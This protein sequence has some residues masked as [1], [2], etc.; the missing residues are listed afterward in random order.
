M[1]A[2]IKENGM[3]YEL[4]PPGQHRRNQAERAIQT[5]KSHFISILAGVDDKFPLSLWC[6]LLEPTELTLNLLRQSRITPNISAFAHVHFN[7]DYMRK[8]FALIGCAIQT[9]VKPDN[10]LSWDTRSEPGFNLGTLMEHHCCF[11]VYVTRTRATRISNTVFFKH[12]YITNPTI[13]PESHV[14]AAAQQLATALKGNI[15]AGN[16]TAEA[17]T[18][19]SDLF[20][21]IAAAKQ[22]TTAAK[23]QQ[24]RLRA[25]PTARITTH[26]PRLVVPLPRVAVPIPRVTEPSQAD[27]RVVQI[28][29]NPTVPRPVEQ[30]PATCSQSRS[31][32]VD[33]QSS[34]ARPNYISQDEEDDDDPPPPATD[35]TLNHPKHHARSNVRVH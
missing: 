2:C 16:E 11:R 12:Q 29:T 7:H 33:V 13:S 26:L 32:Q 24:N 35:N 34:A 17:L 3:T 21:K 10:H 4:V 14:V 18:K 25:N 20:T 31:P 19:V 8:P 5:F 9:H 1:I 23:E 27:C 30:A 28:V 22:A 6:H 15:P